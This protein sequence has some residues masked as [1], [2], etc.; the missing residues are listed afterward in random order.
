MAKESIESALKRFDERYYKLRL[1]KNIIDTFGK[2]L[3]SYM[4][5]INY[6]VQN[7]ETEEHIKNIVNS[8][9]KATFYSD[10]RFEINAYKRVDSAI[11]YN[12]ILYAILEMKKPANK[13]EMVLEDDINKKALWEIVY[14]YL[15]ETRDVSGK[16]VK[17]KYES[18]IRRLIITDSR[19]WVL[20]NAQDLDK[21]CEGYIEKLFYKFENN[22]LNYRDVDK[23]Y[24]ALKEYFFQINITEKLRFVYF[25]IDKMYSRKSNWQYIYKIFKRDYLIKDGYKQITKTHILNGRFYRELLY[26]MGLKEEKVDKK[27]VI[28]IDSSEKGSLANQVYS[29]LVEEKDRPED[30]AMEETFEIILVWINRLLFIKLFEGQLI[31]F[32]GD[33]S[34]YRILD[35]DKIR[36]FQEI[37]YLFFDVLGKRER[38][39]NTFLQQFENIPYLNSSLFERY[40]VEI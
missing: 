18:E 22:Q 25:E 21:I 5:Q 19:A 30:L 20:I 33:F 31:A 9:L 2:N 10:T 23:F 14:Y 17:S 24:S 39:D 36:N 4:K 27:N 40:D 11:T 12:N 28:I 38:E 29:I 3:L 16:K 35:N 8:F 13:T 15:C 1:D 6:A 32:N 7:N 37:Q 34:E 26:L